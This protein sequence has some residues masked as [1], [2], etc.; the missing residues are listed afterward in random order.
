MYF[1][2]L[3]DYFWGIVDSLNIFLFLKK[4]GTDKK[5]ITS[6][7]NIIWFNFFAHMLLEFS[8]LAIMY[9]F[10]ISIHG[11]V[12]V[13][14]YP[15]NLVSALYHLLNYMD[16][17]TMISVKASKNSNK[18]PFLDVISLP[19]TTLIYQFVIFLTTQIIN[20]VLDDSLHNFAFFCNF[21]FL[22]IYHSF[23]CYNNLWQYLKIDISRRIDMH[24][25]LWP[26]YI[27]YGTVATLIYLY[28][29]NQI[30]LGFYNIYLSFVISLPFL[31]KTRYP[32][33]HTGASVYPKKEQRY[34]AINLSIFSYITSCIIYLSRRFSKN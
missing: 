11:L 1:E 2:I 19:I 3:K 18:L 23:Y 27:G 21:I 26:Y 24:E 31:L 32:S 12:T 9:L 6:I 15:I 7:L 33:S 29:D 4:I 10:D 13:L 17:L 34:F 28:S 14:K 22:S 20:L 30:V 8:A 5:I 16:L 25:K